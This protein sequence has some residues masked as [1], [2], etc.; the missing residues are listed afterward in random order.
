MEEDAE[1]AFVAADMEVLEL[2]RNISTKEVTAAFPSK[3]T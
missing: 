2:D 3:I 1:E